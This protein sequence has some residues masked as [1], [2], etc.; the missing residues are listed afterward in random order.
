MTKVSVIIPVYNVEKYLQRCFDSVVNQTLKDIEI[1]LVNDGST[2]SSGEMCDR[3]AKTDNR[4][5]V[6][7]KEN[8]GLSDARNVG[9][10]AAKGEFLSFIDSDDYVVPDM[11]EYLYTN[12]VSSGAQIATGTMRMVKNGQGKTNSDFVPAVFSPEQALENALYGPV[13]SLSVCNK[14]FKKDL[15]NDIKFLVGKTYEDAYIVPSLFLKTDKVFMSGKAVYNYVIDRVDSITNVS[16]SEK[17][18]NMVEAFEFNRK[19]VCEKFPGLFNVFTYRIYYAYV[20]LFKKIIF[21]V[22]FK[23]NKYYVERCY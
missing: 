13:S 16:F 23:N 19:K 1:I 6:I 8:G 2:D 22:D 9:I 4:V 17:N 3:L 18:F 5:K 11:L 7:H 20:M 10:E 15:F 14:I 21:L 12:A